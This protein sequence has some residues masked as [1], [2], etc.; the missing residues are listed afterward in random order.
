M[1]MAVDGA[2]EASIS[3]PAKSLLRRVIVPALIILL[4]VAVLLYP[5]VATQWNNHLQQQ[6][7]EQYAEEMRNRPP[8][9]RDPEIDKAREYNSKLQGGPILDPWLARISEDNA[10]YQHYLDQL[11]NAPAM[12]QLTIPS[13]DL[14]L[15]IYHGT[16]EKTLQMGLGHMYGTSLPLGGAGTHTVVTGHTGITNATLFDNL[17]KVK[18]GDGLYLNTFGEKLKYEVDEIEVVLPDVTDSL[19]LY[20]GEDKLTLITCT[21]YGIN[22]HRLL[23]HAHRVPMDGTETEVFDRRASIMQW[24]MWALIV[25]ALVIVTWLLWWIM[26]ERRRGSGKN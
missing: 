5:V 2:Q 8:E 14:R 19:G 18:R 1:V 26:R 11:G 15:P 16:A 20:P 23:V 6:A 4:G 7:A 13:I 25:L 3:K 24:W 17:D 10:E 9:Q 12:S 22:T 21:P